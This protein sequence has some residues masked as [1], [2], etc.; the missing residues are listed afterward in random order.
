MS[1][2][3]GAAIWRLFLYLVL[4]SAL[5]CLLGWKYKKCINCACRMQHHHHP[6]PSF[7]H[8]IPRKLGKLATLPWFILASRSLWPQKYQTHVLTSIVKW[9]T[10]IPTT[11][12]TS[13]TCQRSFQLEGGCQVWPEVQVTGIQSIRSHLRLS[14]GWMLSLLRKG[15]LT[16]V[17]VRL[18]FASGRRLSACS[19]R[20]TTVTGIRY[21]QN[22]FRTALAVFGFAVQECNAV[23]L[24]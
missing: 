21:T 8:R 3:S 2:F 1:F 24:L 5:S 17:V 12:P 22:S 7:H 20:Q 10:P 6:L 15:F 18:W 9:D 13:T 19:P 23:F 4:Y 16:F 14:A 11:T